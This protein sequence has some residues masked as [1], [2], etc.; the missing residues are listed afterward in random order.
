MISEKYGVMALVFEFWL[1]VII[2]VGGG[3][4]M[5]HNS[6]FIAPI[7]GLWGSLVIFWFSRR[8]AEATA[9]NLMTAMQQQPPVIMQPT[10]IPQEPTAM[11][12]K[13]QPA[14]PNAQQY[15]QPTGDAKNV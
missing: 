3:A 5:W 9:N 6:A 15:M 4:L 8:Q 2:L 10:V 12:I 1:S 14:Q 13:D 11:P 7:F